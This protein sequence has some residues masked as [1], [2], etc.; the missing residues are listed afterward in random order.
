MSIIR[1]TAKS[2]LSCEEGGLLDV[3]ANIEVSVIN[4]NPTVPMIK[5][6]FKRKYGKT[7]N[8]DACVSRLHQEKR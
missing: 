4:Q 7:P 5:D 1:F 8:T 2:P 3:G 6:A